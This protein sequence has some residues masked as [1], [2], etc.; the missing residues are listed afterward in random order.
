MK[1]KI[2]ISLT[3]FFAYTSFSY[4]GWTE[5]GQT[6][7]TTILADPDTVV[8]DGSK[9]QINHMFNH[10]IIGKDPV[11]GSNVK[12]AYGVSQFNC[13]TE[14]YRRIKLALYTEAMGSGDMVSEKNTPNSSWEKIQS[15]SWIIGVFNVACNTFKKR[16]A[17]NKA[18]Y[19][20]DQ[21]DLK[22]VVTS[23][24]DSNQNLDSLNSV[25]QKCLDLGFKQGTEGFGNCVLRL[26]K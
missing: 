11:S 13:E 6:E 8:T 3:I 23:P 5:L 21:Q 1:T 16:T 19:I 2:L 9:V 14:E 18:K 4:A 7:K 25:K 20:A 15:G 22:G 24:K 17:E 10:K 12:S 26:S